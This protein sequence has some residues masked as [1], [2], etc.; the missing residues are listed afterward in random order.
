M[1]LLREA[2]YYT[3]SSFETF[4]FYFSCLFVRLSDIWFLFK[5]LENI[6]AKRMCKT[7][8]SLFYIFSPFLS[9]CIPVFLFL[10]QFTDPFNWGRW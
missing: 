2:I 10:L 9:P 3:F 6:M 8:V 1:C 7:L 5:G 4:Y